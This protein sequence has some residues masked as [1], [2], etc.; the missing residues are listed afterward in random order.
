M[1]KCHFLIIVGGELLSF[2][3]SFFLMEAAAFSSFASLRTIVR[4]LSDRA[5][6]VTSFHRSQRRHVVKCY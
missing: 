4:A 6:S 2:F 5:D 1:V 3:L